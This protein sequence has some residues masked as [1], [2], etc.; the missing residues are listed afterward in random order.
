MDFTVNFN[1][2]VTVSGTP[3]IAL[4][5]ETGGVVNA[6]YIGGTGTSA[7]VF[8]YTVQAGN[9][10]ADGVTVGT[11]INLNGATIKDIGTND[12]ILTLNGIGN[13]TA[14][15]ID[16]V[17]PTISSVD[18]PPHG[19]YISGNNI[20]FTLNFNEAVIVDT[21]GGTPYIPVTF[22]S[23]I[24]NASYVNGSGSNILV[25]QYTIEANNYDP[26]GIEVGS[27]IVLNGGT[28]KDNASN[29]TVLTLNN[30]G[31]TI[32]ILID[33]KAPE[34]ISVEV[35]ANGT[36]KI[37]E[38]LDFTINYNENVLIIGTP[39]IPI[40]LDNG[41]VVNAFYLTGTGTSA[42]TF[43]YT[44]KEGNVDTNGISI[45][46][47]NLNGG[48]IIDLV[49]NNAILTLNSIGNTTGVL[50]D[51]ARPMVSSVSVPTNLIYNIGYIMEFTVKYN[52]NVLVVGGIP[53]IAITL[54]SGDIV[55]AL[56]VGGTGTKAL[57]FRY[58]VQDGDLDTDG[59]IVG[60]EINLNG[61]TIKDAATNNAILILNNIGD[62][63]LVQ[64]DTVS[65]IVSSVSVPANGSYIAGQ[66]MD[67]TVNFN[68]NL[69]VSGTPYI[70]LTLE[71]GGVVNASYIGGTGTSALVFRYTI[72]EGNLDT[73]G[74][75]VG[76]EIN[77]NG[78]MLKDIGTNDAILTLNGI[79]DL[80]TVL[81]DAVAPNVSS[82][83]VPANR[84]YMS[85]QNL[86]FIIKYSET[87]IV[88]TSGGTPSIALTLNT[89]G[90]VNATYVSG[91]GT[92]ELKFR[93]IIQ[94]GNM[95]SN[96][97]E[98]GQNIDLNGGTIK[99][100][101]ANNATL[102]LNNIGITNS[103]L[104]DTV[105]PT[106]A[107]TSAASSLSNVSPVSVTFTF[108]EDVTDF[109]ISDITV[110]NG[111]AENFKI[112]NAYT[113]TAEITPSG[114]GNFT[115]D[116]AEGVAQ[117]LAGNN[118]NVAT[119]LRRIYDSVA[120]NVSNLATNTLAQ[121]NGYIDIIFDEGVY[122]ASDGTTA[123]TPAKF[124]L[125]FTQNTGT[126][127]NVS[128][129]SI[130][131]ANNEDEGAALAL[132]GGENV[133]RIFLTISGIPN[134]TETIEIKPADASSIY[135]Q[136]GNA[137]SP[138]LTTGIKTLN[139]KVLPMVSSVTPTDDSV[140]VDKNTNLV[141]TFNEKVVKGTGDI[142]IR[143][144]SDN[145]VF[146]VI[147]VTSGQ[148]TGSG[149]T[150]ITVNP[151]NELNGSTEYYIQIA[152]SAF[153]DTA[154]NSYSGIMDKTRWS[155]TTTS[156]STN[157]NTTEEQK[158]TNVLVNGKEVNAGNREE[159]EDENGRTTTTL[160]VDAKIIQDRLEE[161]GVGA[162]VTI[163][164]ASESDVIVGQLNG[165]TVKDMEN[166]EA[167]LEVRTENVTYTIPASQIK[168]DKI[169]EDLGV[170]VELKDIQVK[171]TIANPSKDTVEII[172]K[173]ANTNNYRIVVKPIEFEITCTYDNQTVT[174]SKFNGYVERLVAIPDGIDSSKITT[175]IVLNEDGTFSHVPTTIIVVDGKHYAKINS[176]TNSTYSVIYSPKE[177]ADLEGHWAQEDI[178]DMGS[179][180]IVSGINNDIYDPNKD[181]T[182]AEFAA[183]I[184]R[185]LG[186]MRSNVGET[187]F[188]DVYQTDWYYE[189]VSIAYEYG[190]IEGVGGNNF[191][192]NN[193]ITRQEA[194]V[195][196]SRAMKVI[197][198]ID[199]TLASQEITTLLGEYT[200]SDKLDSWAKQSAAI[201][202][203]KDI[204]TG[205]NKLLSGKENITRAETAAIVRRLLKKANLI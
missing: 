47:I 71:T 61:T 90:L 130:K 84:S 153:K 112:V 99:D 134:G 149:T 87:V 18:V 103:V 185:A 118:N 59:V 27:Q 53:S 77:L 174:V 8:R 202:I 123:L 166:V 58:T 89:G 138:T 141:I 196:I 107:I 115:V 204:I 189:A 168:I 9:L 94:V 11:E 73:D 44:V 131:K 167:I 45:E 1:E 101:G 31:N 111:I 187:V 184:V 110:G 151:T 54:D 24:V 193:K 68:E 165:Q 30:T 176:L 121:N 16:G 171:V 147:D 29:N 114:Q 52:E 191:N 129:S 22:A 140:E 113:Y 173:T 169:S 203:D 126:A 76:S 122:G 143:K 197:K 144:T 51:A 12:A 127:T 137:S 4:T 13:P 172:E 91:S 78:A 135:D 81:V 186:L 41:V 80:T 148:V 75:A 67:F 17:L 183:I 105:A 5:L 70:T 83:G 205:Y 156:L 145:S 157:T 57:V 195:M 128:I 26:N 162:V 97:I 39:F 163:P 201:C 190:I 25:F 86:D 136:A 178:N 109:S 194:M 119:Q 3:Y 116:I 79:G 50:V 160:L 14:V 124:V 49:S 38:Y 10:D 7:L 152:V 2:N 106:L 65:P 48:T 28:I 93:Y 6:S 155:F 102:T 139:D 198:K 133:V 21:S 34:V 104:I 66:N 192:P 98:I 60:T 19:T 150:V 72:Q 159:T 37:G 108:D 158:Y 154:G 56:Y 74:V 175:G 69:I 23:G 170:G 33:T 36:Y 43:R 161:E 95:D 20:S 179:R 92:N 100:S 96:G 132:T 182:R 15:L 64:I 180:L 42:P 85:E 164:V 82:V 177:F 88:N 146:E 188:Q 32:G 200:D 46:A 55:N 125:I 62:T 35:P 40:T 63:T 120:P 181:I 117:D 142:T 199:M